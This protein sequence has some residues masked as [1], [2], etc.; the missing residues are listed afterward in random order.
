MLQ[1]KS[2]VFSAFLSELSNQPPNEKL[3]ND[4]KRK[5][6][7]CEWERLYVEIERARAAARAM[8]ERLQIKALDNISEEDFFDDEGDEKPQNQA[9]DV[10]EVFEEERVSTVLRFRLLLN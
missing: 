8:S 3:T 6:K 5:W 7:E 2:P 9:G 10:S 1:T 4:E